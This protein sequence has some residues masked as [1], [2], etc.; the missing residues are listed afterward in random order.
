MIIDNQ[1][2]HCRKAVQGLDSYFITPLA[3]ETTITNT[4]VD[5]VQYDRY[6]PEFH[7]ARFPTWFAG[8]LTL[9]PKLRVDRKMA[10]GALTLKTPERIQKDLKPSG[11]QWDGTGV[12]TIRTRYPRMSPRVICASASSRC[13]TK[14]HPLVHSLVNQSK[15]PCHSARQTSWGSWPGWGFYCPMGRPCEAYLQGTG[16]GKGGGVHESVR[17]GAVWEKP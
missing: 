13:V 2:H 1:E 6:L 4:K 17:K 14:W 16:Y 11:N 3:G 12:I 8:I 7:L 9:S 5:R 10:K 15:R